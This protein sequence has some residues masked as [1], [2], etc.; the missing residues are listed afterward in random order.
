[1]PVKLIKAG[2]LGLFLKFLSEP[3]SN[4]LDMSKQPQFA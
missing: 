1:M 3:V 4:S 2:Q